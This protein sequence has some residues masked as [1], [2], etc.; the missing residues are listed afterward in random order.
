MNFMLLFFLIMNLL[1]ISM[2]VIGRCFI[3][4]PKQKPTLKAGFSLLLGFLFLFY[5]ISILGVVGISL[6]HHK[7]LAISLLA[8]IAIP[9]II[10]KK[11]TY[12]KL[13]FYSN[14]QLIMFLV[15]LLASYVLIKI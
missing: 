5:F 1:F 2:F 4:K 12:E 7:Y 8:F 10:G 15:S 6:L 14:L 13:H 3:F 9:F 11:A